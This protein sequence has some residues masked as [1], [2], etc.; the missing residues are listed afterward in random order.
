[1]VYQ[2]SIRPNPDDVELVELE[3]GLYEFK[4]AYEGSYHY[5]RP[6]RTAELKESKSEPAHLFT[7]AN[8]TPKAEIK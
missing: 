4:N 5:F 6:E 3:N 2:S 8:V 7:S 1:M